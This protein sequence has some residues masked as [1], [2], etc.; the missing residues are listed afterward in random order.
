MN[1]KSVAINGLA[2]L[3]LSQSLWEHVKRAVSTIN[4]SEVSGAQKRELV[5]QEIAIV[6]GHLA[7]SMINFAIELGVMWLKSKSSS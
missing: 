6:F 2:K 3:L 7:E 5:K 4:S 1:V